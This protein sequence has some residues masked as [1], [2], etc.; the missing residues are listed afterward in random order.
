MA[1]RPAVAGTGTF[2]RDVSI[3]VVANLVAAAIIYL[4][5]AL[6]GLFPHYRSALLISLV[7]LVAAVLPVAWIVIGAAKR[8]W[9]RRVA[10]I[11]LL[12]ANGAWAVTFWRARSTSKLSTT[13]ILVAGSLLLGIGALIMA[14]RPPKDSAASPAAEADADGGLPSK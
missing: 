6:V 12:L 10:G 13:L 14:F 7:T 5:G 2:I 4:A 3:N 9:V 1:A 11:L 8:M